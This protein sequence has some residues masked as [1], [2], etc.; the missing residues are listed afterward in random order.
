MND[1]CCCYSSKILKV[2]TKAKLTGAERA[3]RY[4]EKRKLDKKRDD[5]YK[6]KERER[7]TL[8]FEN[9]GHF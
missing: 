1:Y 3:K 2:K 8:Y 6:K 9:L 4:R 7:Y 5:E